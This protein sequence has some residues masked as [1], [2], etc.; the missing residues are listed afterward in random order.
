MKILAIDP[1]TEKSAWVVFDCQAFR[2]EK[3]GLTKN[4][5]LVD[6]RLLH[7]LLARSA[8]LIA[9]VIKSYGNVI[10]DSTLET[11]VWLGRFYQVAFDS[12]I[13]VVKYN[14]RQI[15]THICGGNSRAGDRQVRQALIDR[16]PPLGGGAVPSIGTKKQPGPLF[17]VSR[18]VWSAIAV[19]VTY[20]ELNGYGS[21]SFLY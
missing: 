10:G 5:D 12:E 16:F 21:S 2:V 18:D 1:G 4:V 6:S 13:P 17:G 20:A 14:R 3:F 9:E 15:V 7:D 8:R 19:A 11:C